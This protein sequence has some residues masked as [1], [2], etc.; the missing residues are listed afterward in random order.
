MKVQSNIPFPVDP[1]CWKVPGQYVIFYN[2]IDNGIQKEGDEGKR[3]E[4]EMI[5]VNALDESTIVTAKELN[6]VEPDMMQRIIDGI[7]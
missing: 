5:V 1:Q 2:C 4:A 3:Y 7:E 6:E